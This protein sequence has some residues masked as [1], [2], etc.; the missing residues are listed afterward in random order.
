MQHLQGCIGC[1]SQVR[2]QA[3]RE[4]V[5]QAAQALMVHHLP[6]S[7][8]EAALSCQR[9]AC[10]GKGESGLRVYY[11]GLIQDTA[12]ALESAVPAEVLMSQC[13]LGTQA[14]PGCLCTAMRHGL[15]L[16]P[17]SDPA[18]LSQSGS[19]PHLGA[20]HRLMPHSALSWRSS[21]QQGIWAWTA[22]FPDPF[23]WPSILSPSTP[24]SP[25]QHSRVRLSDLRA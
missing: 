12:R 20:R 15:G 4:A 7:R 17:M 6:G 2:G 9:V 23:I 25:A 24:S 5:A 8:A 22:C 10:R 19:Q 1:N 13:L 11:K 18:V 14:V 16:S 3:G 21:L